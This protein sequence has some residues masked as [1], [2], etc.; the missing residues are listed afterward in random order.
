MEVAPETYG[1]VC[2]E[3]M[4]RK[5][6]FRPFYLLGFFQWKNPAAKRAPVGDRG[7]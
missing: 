2:G 6:V 5:D 3:S 7:W 4:D 1:D